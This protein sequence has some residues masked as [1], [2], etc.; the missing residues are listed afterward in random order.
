M[1]EKLINKTPT[2]DKNII[3]LYK[4]LISVVLSIHSQFI[5]SGSGA[6]SINKCLSLN[7]K[8]FL[9]TCI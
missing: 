5:S 1:H 2:V 8:D 3:N 9:T 7:F 6:Y 4:S